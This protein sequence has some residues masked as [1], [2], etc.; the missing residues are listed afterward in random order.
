MNA[1]KAVKISRAVDIGSVLIGAAVGGP[2]GALMLSGAVITGAAGEV[3]DS[4]LKR[5]KN[6]K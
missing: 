1:E 5:R 4:G 3:I 2:L 6:K